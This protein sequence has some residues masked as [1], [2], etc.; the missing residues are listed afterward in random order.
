MCVIQSLLL[1]DI[2]CFNLT[3]IHWEFCN[4]FCSTS[5]M[6]VCMQHADRNHTSKLVFTVIFVSTFF[7]AAG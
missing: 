1:C 5:V 4:I 3:L 2:V 6:F 7:I